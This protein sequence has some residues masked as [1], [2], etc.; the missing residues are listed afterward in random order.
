MYHCPE[1]STVLVPAEGAS[2]TDSAP[3]GLYLDTLYYNC[4]GC[5]QQFLYRKKEYA[6][7]EPSD[8]WYH[9]APGGKTLLMHGAPSY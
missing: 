1:C 9:I 2:R 3:G 6:D 5:G 8:E 7:R 4:P